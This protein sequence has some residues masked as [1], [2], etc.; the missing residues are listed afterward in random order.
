MLLFL[1]HNETL[2]EE[3]T[4]RRRR[5]HTVYACSSNATSAASRR[6]NSVV[7]AIVR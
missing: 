1:K 7:V 2:V 6:F 3:D 5:P 4:L